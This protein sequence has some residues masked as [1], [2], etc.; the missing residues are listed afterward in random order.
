MWLKH[1][2][3]VNFRNYNHLSLD[4][5]AGVNVVIGRNA[6]GKTNL[7]EAIYYLGTGASPR[8]HRDLQVLQE[9]ESF[10]TLEGEIKKGS[11]PRVGQLSRHIRLVYQ[12]PGSGANH[13]Q[14]QLFLDRVK[15]ERLGEVLGEF[16]V[17]YFGPEQVNLVDGPPALRRHYLDG[18]ICQAHPEHY[19]NLV[20]YRRVL[21]QRNRLLKQVKWEPTAESQLEIW[22]EELVRLSQAIISRRVQALTWLSQSASRW[23]RQIGGDEELGLVYCPTW[24]AGGQKLK[25]LDQA[26]VAWELKQALKANRARE[27]KSG[28][29]MVGPHLDEITILIDGKEARS[30]AS[31]GQQRTAVVALKLAELNFLEEESQEPAVLLLDDVFSELDEGRRRLLTTSLSSKNQVFITTSEGL[32]DWQPVAAGW[33][34]VEAGRV[35][36]ERWKIPE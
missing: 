27:I 28:Y 15:K 32:G 26:Q 22:D 31:R 13:G 16:N 24:G 29:T 1:L 17:V 30:F 5:H 18:Q 7:L 14:K 21:G 6:Q 2:K 20:R 33:Y 3:V 25:G 35:D 19:Y 10:F 9:G 36:R 4:F 23:Q 11:D 12:A 34:L 8:K